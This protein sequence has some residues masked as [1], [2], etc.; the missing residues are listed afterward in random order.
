MNQLWQTA[1]IS[2]T[3]ETLVSGRTQC[4]RP[5]ECAYP[6]YGHGWMALCDVHGAR[7]SEATPLKELLAKGER[8]DGK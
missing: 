5:T 1:P 2:P 6:A 4:S 8:M 3:C 7:H